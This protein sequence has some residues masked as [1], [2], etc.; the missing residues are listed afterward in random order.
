VIAH[1]R[2]QSFW[3]AL[4]RRLCR[5]RT[6]SR[7][8]GTISPTTPYVVPHPSAESPP[9]R[10]RELA[11]LIESGRVGETD[12]VIVVVHCRDHAEHIYAFG[13]RADRLSA[14]GILQIAAGR[15]AH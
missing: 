2:G 8:R 11:D 12:G 6:S 10:L 4:W 9:Q 7:S 1:S 13:Q 3:T 5:A 15:M 14:I